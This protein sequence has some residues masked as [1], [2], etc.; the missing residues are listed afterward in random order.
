[1]RTSRHNDHQDAL[2][3]SDCGAG[4]A[5][6]LRH[7][8]RRQAQ[9]AG[10]GR[11]GADPAVRRRRQRSI[12]RS[13]R[14]RCCCPRPRRMRRGR[15]P[16][17]TRPNRWAISRLA[18]RRCGPGPRR[19]RRQRIARG[20]PRRR[21]SPAARLYVVDVDAA[22]STPLTPRPARAFGAWRPPRDATKRHRASAA[23]SASRASG[24]TRPMAWAMWWRSTSPTVRKS[25]A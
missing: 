1:M 5:Q 19:S 8:R 14:C 13:P 3:R 22:R 11:A 7:F 25:G 21:S 16:A 20:W 18:H 23:A 4:G 10:A 24:S 9:D 17:A 2:C 12:R 6:R 15:S